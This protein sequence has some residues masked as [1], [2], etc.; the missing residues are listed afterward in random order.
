MWNKLSMKDRANYIRLA[1]KNNIKNLDTIRNI[2][3]QYATGGYKNDRG[4]E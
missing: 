1:V 4:E 2:Y 3:N